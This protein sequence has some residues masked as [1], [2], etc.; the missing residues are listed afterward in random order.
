MFFRELS[1]AYFRHND[2]YVAFLGER[3]EQS[4]VQMN[5]KQIMTRELEHRQK[6][7]ELEPLMGQIREGLTAHQTQT[8]HTL[9][10]G[11]VARKEEEIERLRVAGERQARQLAHLTDYSPENVRYVAEH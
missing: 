5:I 8:Q 3:K 9:L 1:E 2:D 7:K 11:I 10:D 6:L 4:G